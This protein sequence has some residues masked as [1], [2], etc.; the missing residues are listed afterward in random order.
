MQKE[1]DITHNVKATLTSQPVEAGAQICNVAVS[2]RRYY[3][4]EVAL[5]EALKRHLKDL[6]PSPE[7]IPDAN[8][9]LTILYKGPANPSLF[10]RCD[11][12]L[13]EIVD[14]KLSLSGLRGDEMGTMDF[15]PSL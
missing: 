7:F 4:T 11:K 9:G 6:S 2:D 5:R 13:Q 14:K 10:D 12:I 3:S 15:K 1:F 8:K